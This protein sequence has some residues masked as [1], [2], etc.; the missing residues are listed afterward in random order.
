MIR[1]YLL[2]MIN[3]YKNKGEWIIQISA[4]IS[5]FSSKSDS[6]KHVLCIQ[7]VIT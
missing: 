4:E 5:F 7:K 1:P 3:D 2:A 6:G